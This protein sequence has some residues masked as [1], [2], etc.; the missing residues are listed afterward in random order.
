MKEFQKLKKACSKYPKLV[1]RTNEKP[2]IR[3]RV[4]GKAKNG[5]IN[6]FCK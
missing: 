6:K 1:L 2:K 3:K 5:F 4:K